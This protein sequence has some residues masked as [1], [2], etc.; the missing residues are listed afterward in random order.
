M[1]C[2]SCT[3][4]RPVK[5]SADDGCQ[6]LTIKVDD[7]RLGCP[8]DY[9]ETVAENEST[10]CANG[11]VSNIVLAD[12]V[13]APEP[14]VCIELTNPEDVD[15]TNEFTF[16]K[17]TDEA[18]DQYNLTPV[19]IKVLN[20]DHQCVLDS[21]KGQE[22]S[23]YYKL[24]NKSGDYVWRRFIG[25]LTGVTGGLINGYELTFNADNPNENERPLFVNLGSEALTTA[26][27]DAIT[28]F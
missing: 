16:D 7:I 23:I 13:A 19:G 22:V 9:T 10:G 8:E 20:P 17:D 21:L 1:S 3:I 18:D 15:E 27:I 5:D 6:K 25:C 11:Y 12:P 14:L 2:S 24:E 26:A 28:Q 4:L